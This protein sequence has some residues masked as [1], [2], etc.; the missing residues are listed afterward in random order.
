[1]AS[2]GWWCAVAYNMSHSEEGPY[3]WSVYRPFCRIVIPMLCHLVDSSIPIEIT[4]TCD[5]GMKIDV[6]DDWKHGCRCETVHCNK[7]M[8]E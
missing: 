1:M 7:G 5:E 6:N 3:G 4:N 2:S 8:L